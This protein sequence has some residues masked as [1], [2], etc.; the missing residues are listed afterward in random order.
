MQNMS[1]KNDLKSWVNFLLFGAFRQRGRG[2]GGKICRNTIIEDDI[3]CHRWS[4][5]LQVAALFVCLFVHLSLCLSVCL[6]TCLLV[7]TSLSVCL[8]VCLLSHLFAC[9]YYSLLSVCSLTCL[10]VVTSLSVCLSVFSLV[11]L[12]LSVCLPV[13]LS[14]YL[15]VCLPVCLSV[16]DPLSSK[17]ISLSLASSTY[18]NQFLR[19]LCSASNQSLFSHRE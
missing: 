10:L 15:S 19:K 13:C 11:C 1:R 12:C 5:L 6:L 3:L 7:V 14:V 16:C 17:L 8:S 9:C 18:Q 2:A 4:V